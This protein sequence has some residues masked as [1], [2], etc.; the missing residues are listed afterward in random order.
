MLRH[1]AACLLALALLLPCWRLAHSADT[2]GRI[3]FVEG[4]VRIV[5]PDRKER[6][7]VKGEPVRVAETIVSGQDGEVH[8]RMDD[9]GYLAVRPGTRLVIT[10]YRARGDA[11][12]RSVLKLLVGTFRSI[13]GWIPRVAPRNYRI[14]ALTATI[15]V[16]GTDHEP[17]VVEKG[18]PQGLAGL[19]D[20][21]NYGTTF[22]DHPSG[23]I[24]IL[25]GQAGYAPEEE[26]GK[27]R[28][29]EYLPDFFR[30]T[31]NEQLLEGRHKSIQEQLDQ[32][33]EERR[34]EVRKAEEQ[35]APE[36]ETSAKARELPPEGGGAGAGGGTGLPDVPSVPGLPGVGTAGAAA[37]GA[38]GAAVSGGGA[39]AGA[40]QSAVTGAGEAARAA[41]GT[42][43]APVVTRGGG[44][45]TPAAAAPAAK[46]AS[47]KAAPPSRPTDGRRP[48]GPRG[49]EAG[50][51]ALPKARP[52]DSAV[53]EDRATTLNEKRRKLLEDRRTQYEI[54][55]DTSQNR[56]PDR[57][58]EPDRLE[59]KRRREAR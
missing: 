58:R 4:D 6:R 19:Y 33:L 30:A 9:S 54:D 39:A 2:A 21:V 57:E 38:A 42:P 16:R 45:A 56:D 55:R 10:D 20:K 26:K 18:S 28:V 59:A 15:G 14:E 43:P 52:A 41:V 1:P 37:A 5:A 32:R 13:T 12:D 31:R 47:P 27:V 53:P 49:A 17:F 51:A 50:A 36:K 24:D 40:A 25:Q 44:E 3:E 8:V 34:Q 48:P 35:K 23:S 29:L 22:I 7:A 11:E 46:E